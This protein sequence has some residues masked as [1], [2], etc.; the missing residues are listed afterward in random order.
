MY[1]ASE[2]FH[3]AV[4][5]GAHQIALLIFD[6]AVF[7]NDD[8]NVT[9]GIEFN[10]YF[11]TEENLAIGQALSNEISFS[12]F[13]DHRLLNDYEFGEF[14]ATI[15]AQ[16]G[17]ETV[18][19]QGTIQ[20]SSANHTYV[21]YSD[22]PYLKRDG[23]AV[24]SQPARAIKSMLM[25]DG[26]LYCLLANNT[27]IGYRDSNGSTKSVSVNSFMKMQMARWEGKGIAYTKASGENYKLRIWKG[28]N[29]RT[30][31]FVPLGVFNA[32]RPNVPYVNEIHFTC[33]D[34]MQ[35]FEEDMPSDSELGLTYPCTF[36]SLFIKLCTYAG[37]QYGSTYFINSTATLS[38]R[39]EDFDE[40]TM[41]E[42]L[43][44]IAEAAA[45]VAR[46]NRN[47][48][49]TMDWLRT[50]SQSFNETGYSEFNPYWY[51]TKAVTK[52][53]NRATDGSYSKTTGSGDEAYLI[54]DNPLLKEVE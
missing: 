12:I 38:E 41:R 44:W 27:V 11:N 49:L 33:Y 31:E 17:N 52:L 46:F 7:T 21:A 6:D 35:R 24:S 13:N 9:A 42:V 34:R 19:A 20:V 54:Q 26:T 43:Q 53:Y 8:I 15:G 29:K 47:G 45:S 3:E 36:S 50:T 1:S 51:E 48:V 22:S 32:E 18:T 25:Y 23:T 14:T 4:A 10:D 39:P 28:T 40:A 30:Y 5:N 16:I 37:V 2:A